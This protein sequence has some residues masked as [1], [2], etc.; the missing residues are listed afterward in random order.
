MPGINFR[1]ISISLLLCYPLLICSAET[2]DE[3]NLDGFRYFITGHDAHTVQLH[4]AA[5]NDGLELADRHSVAHVKFDVA[6]YGEMSFPLNIDS[7]PGNE[8]TRVDLSRS[9][10]IKLT[11]RSNSPVIL[12]LRE[13]GVHGG[14]QNHI[15]L[16][17]AKK[18]TTRTVYFSEFS[19]GLKTL[20]LTNVA[21]FNFALLANNEEDGFAELTVK[22]MVIDNFDPR[23]KR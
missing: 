4:P 16:A 5:G 18:Y 7:A 19:G 13:T 11:Y 6:Q 14:V 23:K 3:K 8:A 17:A 21:K 15:T 20:D 12:Q 2:L 10:Y 22:H 9:K 1:Y